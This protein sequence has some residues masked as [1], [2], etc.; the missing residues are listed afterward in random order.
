MLGQPCR[1]TVYGE[2]RPK[3]A[4]V[5]RHCLHQCVSLSCR[6]T[7][8]PYSTD[9]ALPTPAVFWVKLGRPCHF[10]GHRSTCFCCLPDG[11]KWLSTTFLRSKAFM[12]LAHVLWTPVHH[13]TTQKFDAYLALVA[14]GKC[15]IHIMPTKFSFIRGTSHKRFCCQDSC[16][17]CNH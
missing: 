11:N 12:R 4:A 9:I 3:Q 16:Q 5:S 6:L 8:T 17:F 15:G 2:A 7:I 1:N 14:P 10:Y 13:D